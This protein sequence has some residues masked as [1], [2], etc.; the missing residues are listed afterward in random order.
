MTP[1]QIATIPALLNGVDAVVKAKTG[2]G[3]TVAFLI[4]AIEVQNLIFYFYH[5]SVNRYCLRFY[6]R[7]EFDI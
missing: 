3:K 6:S 2:T 5:V 7:N 4:P 1:V